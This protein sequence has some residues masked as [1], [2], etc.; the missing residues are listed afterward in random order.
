MVDRLKGS[1]SSRTNSGSKSEGSG[2]FPETSPVGLLGTFCRDAR[3]AGDSAREEGFLGVFDGG[4]DVRVERC[5]ACSSAIL[6]SI[7]P[8][9]RYGRV[10]P[11]LLGFRAS[12]LKH[13]ALAQYGNTA[14]G[15]PSIVYPERQQMQ[16]YIER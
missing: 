5:L 13:G 1:E 10:R 2:P 9:R 6:E 7:A 16:Q 8:L 14:W 12:Y 4:G 3:L 11:S 15:C